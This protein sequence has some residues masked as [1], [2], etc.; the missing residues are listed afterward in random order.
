MSNHSMTLLSVLTATHVKDAKHAVAADVCQRAEHSLRF[1]STCMQT[2]A[3]KTLSQC[4]LQ[5]EETCLA[6]VKRFML[7]VLELAGLDD[8]VLCSILFREICNSAVILGPRP[9]G[10]SGTGCN[11]WTDL[12]ATSRNSCCDWQYVPTCSCDSLLAFVPC[13]CKCRGTSMQGSGSSGSC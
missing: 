3:L 8:H 5:P 11:S 6:R 1:H 4:K 12:G 9:E 13:L 2:R 7:E 10:V